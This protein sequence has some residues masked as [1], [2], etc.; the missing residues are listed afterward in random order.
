[1][2]KLNILTCVFFFAMVPNVFSQLNASL[3]GDAVNQGDNCYLVTPDLNDQYGAVWYGNV[4]DFSADFE[5]VFDAYFG[6]ND[7]DGADGM[8]LVFKTSPT[9]ELGGLGGEI[10]YGGI[11]SSLAVEFDTWQNPELNDPIDDHIGLMINGVSNHNSGLALA[12]FPNLEN[13]MTHEIK[14]YWNASLKKISITKDCIEIISYLGD[15]VNVAL[16]GN[17]YAYFGFT[18]STGGAKNEQRICFKY[19][20]FVES[21]LDQD[22]CKGDALNTIDTSFSGAT[23]YSWEPTTGV[24]DPTI[25]N[26]T[27]SPS[28]DTTYEVTITETCGNIYTE[29]FTITVH[30]NPQAF[31]PSN[32]VSCESDLGMAIFDLSAKDV[33]ITNGQ[34]NVMVR[35]YATQID[36]ET[37]TAELASPY[38]TESTTVFARVENDAI[39]YC[40]AFTSL[41]LVVNPSPEFTIETPQ[42]VCSSD[43]T[44]TIVLDPLEDYPSEIYTYEWKD[45]NDLL[46]SN[47]TTLSVSTSG[48]YHVTLTKTDG[49]G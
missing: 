47:N 10:G 8:A 20:S 31:T 1:M 11:A 41:N 19:I 39:P 36:A 38:E 6:N 34:E 29:S 22:I 2:S 18:G 42:I 35:Y 7:A 37:S 5:I 13:G 40:T 27:F 28:T 23:S 21:V 17:T 44:F 3:L 46:L 4:I 33:E 12:E 14:F 49:T 43:P 24:S 32:M 16:N 25:P 30:E 9:P 48:L 15:I 26:P 45:E